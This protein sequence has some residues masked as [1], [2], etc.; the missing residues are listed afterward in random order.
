MKYAYYEYYVERNGRYVGA[1]ELIEESS[2]KLF[3]QKR[4]KQFQLSRKA[5]MQRLAEC[6]L[7][8][9][10]KVPFKDANELLE[11]VSNG[12]EG[13]SIST[14]SYL[15]G[16]LGANNFKLNGNGVYVCS[17]FI[18]DLE[19]F[20]EQ[21]VKI[22][23]LHRA[24]EYYMG[25]EKQTFELPK[26]YENV[27]KTFNEH[28]IKVS[29][30]SSVSLNFEQLK[31]ENDT[32]RELNNDLLSQWQLEA[33]ERLTPQQ[34]KLFDE[35]PNKSEITTKTTG[36]HRDEKSKQ[37]LLDAITLC[38][39]NV[40]AVLKPGYKTEK[41][42]RV[43]YE[44]LNIF[45]V[46][47]ISVIEAYK[48][49]LGFVNCTKCGQPHYTMIRSGGVCEGCLRARRQRK[50][51]VKRDIQKGKSLEEIISSRRTSPEELTELYNEIIGESK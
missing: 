6:F 3:E 43:E 24:Y 33:Y 9:L 30:E 12:V 1:G 15:L 19:W 46:Y 10:T 50:I 32:V 31:D 51:N 39:D 29:K 37:Q 14:L 41:D 47:V 42:I 26:R 38:M 8:H 25:K 21:L 13:T 16:P 35:M 48:K 36:S 49:N 27:R 23:A 4:S 11:K 34:Q 28:L 40:R 5:S 17:S 18:F 20:E 45:G 7:P 2:S 44:P 22:Q